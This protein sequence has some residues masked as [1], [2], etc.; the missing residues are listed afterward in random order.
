M[1][2]TMAYFRRAGL[3]HARSFIANDPIPSRDITANLFHRSDNA[4]IYGCK[5]AKRSLSDEPA[6][7]ER[8]QN[9]S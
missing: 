7:E 1:A 2:N 9:V 5:A 8:E 3:H 4:G 6:C